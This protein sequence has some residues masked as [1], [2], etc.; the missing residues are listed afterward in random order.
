MKHRHI[1][2]WIIPAILALTFSITWGQPPGEPPPGEQPPGEQPPDGQPSKEK[3]PKGPKAPE[4]PEIPVPPG[5]G[6]PNER[7]EGGKFSEST[8][9]EDHS[10]EVGRHP[11]HPFGITIDAHNGR[12]DFNHLYH[13]GTRW[14]RFPI[15]F[16]SRAGKTVDRLHGGFRRKDLHLFQ[17]LAKRAGLSPML[18]ISAG[19]KLPEDLAAY[20]RF[21]TETVKQYG[22]PDTFRITHYEIEHEPNLRGSWSDGP[23]KYAELL[24]RA[25]RAVKTA[26]PRAR[27]ILGGIATGKYLKPFAAGGFLD[28][29]LG[30][31]FSD[32]TRGRDCF[33][34]VDIHLYG[35]APEIRATLK[36]LRAFL[37]KHGIRCPV[38]SSEMGC[39]SRSGLPGPKHGGPATP[40][41]TPRSQAAELVK[42]LVTALACGIEKVFW[43]GLKDR[44][45]SREIDLF[46]YMG[47][48]DAG[49]RKKSSYYTFRLMTEK[50]SGVKLR[51]T[52]RIDTGDPTIFAYRFERAKGKGAIYVLW[53]EFK[54]GSRVKGEKIALP[55]G[56][57]TARVTRAVVM[58]EGA[59]DTVEFRAETGKATIA[60]SPEPVYVE[61]LSSEKDPPAKKGLDWLRKKGPGR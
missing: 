31:R 51:E 40:A 38:W 15:A 4:V 3:G 19:R 33:D 16:P 35:D 24:R 53:R 2:P 9:T 61:P 6:E 57:A 30:H 37:G 7:A 25:H 46:R 36:A 26:D 56:A 22:R 13:L 50:L 23:E 45:S 8:A 39:P 11:G 28:R 1:A 44:V 48:E 27:V 10:K 21:V 29:V 5:S 58:K 54:K 34:A 12:I 14:T 17:R 20:S 42:R 49:G 18:V 43:F 59:V 41:P 52:P 32:G 55:I 47:L 60:V